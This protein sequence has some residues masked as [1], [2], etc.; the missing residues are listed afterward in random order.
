MGAHEEIGNQARPRAPFRAP[1]LA[2]QA[3][4]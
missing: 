3:T 2:P 1:V 4:G